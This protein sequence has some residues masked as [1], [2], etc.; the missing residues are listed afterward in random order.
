[1]QIDGDLVSSRSDV[2]PADATA[3]V[4]ED[5]RAMTGCGLA[6]KHAVDFFLALVGVICVLPVL[7]EQLPTELAR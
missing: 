5:R 2:T 1:M 4:V 7:P 3:F 6:A